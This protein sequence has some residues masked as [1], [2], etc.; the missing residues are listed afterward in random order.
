MKATML[1]AALMCGLLSGGPTMA[2]AAP[3]GDLRLSYHFAP[4]DETMGYRLYVPATYDGKT[5]MPLVVVLHGSGSTED[6]VFDERS[7]PQL[8]RLADQRGYI[9]LAPRGYSAAGG[10]GDIYPVVVTRETAEAGE[11]LA[12]KRLAAV[13][14]AE[15]AGLPIPPI[16][17]RAGPRRPQ[18]PLPDVAVPADDFVD[19]AKGALSDWKSNGLSEQEVMAALDQVRQTYRIDPAR[20]YLMG[21]SMGG[22]GAA[23]LAVRYPDVW[24]AVA[25]AGGPVAAWSYPFGRL[26]AAKLPMLFVHGQYDEHANPHWAEVLASAGR[27]EGVDARALV[28]KGGHHGDAWIMALPEIFD[29]FDAHRRHP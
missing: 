28:V 13:A 21:N 22:V 10:F 18:P 26:R 20:I 3:T 15:A 4:T 1:G 12:A 19:Q 17:P 8:E 27:A 29:F 16:P 11:R 2:A 6:E 14:D 23:Y 7:G 5:A 9:I 24:A 25:P